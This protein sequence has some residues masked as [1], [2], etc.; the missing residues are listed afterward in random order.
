MKKKEG[1]AQKKSFSDFKNNFGFN[2][3]NGNKGVIT[4]TNAD[5]DMDWLIMPKGY[6]D[7]L[8][9]PGIPIGFVSTVC[10]HSNTGKSTI[11]NQA[12]TSAQHKNMIPVIIDTENNFSFEYAIQMGMKATPI[13]GDVEKEIVDEET[14]EITDVVTENKIVNWEGDFIYLNSA[15][16][17][18]KYGFRNYSTGKDESKCRKLAVI[19][20]VARCINELLDAQDNNDLD[21]GL[22]FIW[23]S[24]GSIGSFKSYNSQVGNNMWDAGSISQAFNTIVNNRIPGSRK[25]SSEYS[26]TLIFVNKVWMDNTSSPVGPA[27]I[28]LKGGEQIYYGSR[29][30]ILCGGQLK[31]ATKKLTAISKGEKYNYGIQTKVKILKNQLSAPYNLTY[32]GEFCCTAHGIVAIDELDEYRKTHINDIIKTLNDIIKNNGKGE[33]EITETDI[34]FTEE[35]GTE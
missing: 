14:G 6:Q 7:A 5:K 17:A 26:N 30:I 4:A 34:K 1:I 22:V 29:L 20:D 15:M 35:E 33:K 9:L 13:Y 8:K 27:S 23:D 32:E 2:A 24:V 31:S 3:E 21:R 10:G 18:Q 19:E 12:I 25:T 16:L 11:V 28:T